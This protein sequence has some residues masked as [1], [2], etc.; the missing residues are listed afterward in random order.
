MSNLGY[1]MT[2]ECKVVRRKHMVKGRVGMRAEDLIKILEKVPPNATVDEVIDDC[3][4]CVDVFS[5]EFH[6]EEVAQ[7]E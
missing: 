7:G 4:D 3:V 5:I 2:A 6:E 1:T